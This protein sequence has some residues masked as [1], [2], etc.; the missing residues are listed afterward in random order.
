MLGRLEPNRIK[1]MT[2]CPFHSGSEFES[3]HRLLSG[4]FSSEKY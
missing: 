4:E 2:V 3:S 1:A